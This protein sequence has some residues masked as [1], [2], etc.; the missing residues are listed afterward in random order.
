MAKSRGQRELQVGHARARANIALAKYWGK[1]DRRLNLPAVP[2]VSLTLDRLVTETQVT[3]DPAL[4]EDRIVLDGRRLNPG[5][6]KRMVE[7][8]RTIRKEAGITLRAEVRSENH[9][10]TAAGLASSASGFAAL[11]AATRQ[12]AGLPLDMNAMGRLARRSSASAARSLYGGFC[13]L[14]AGKTNDDR[15]CAKPLH[16]EHH[17]PELRL[18]V[19][20]TATGPKDVG[21]TDGMERSRKTS[22]LYDAWVAAAP[23]LT[24]KVKK[25]LREKNLELLGR[26]MEQSTMSFHSCAHS[27]DP[28]LVY[29]RPATLAAL[30]T[31][32]GLRKKGVSVYATMDAGPHVKSLCEKADLRRVT[33][34]LKR[35]EGVLDV[36]TCGP[37][38]GIEMW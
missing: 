15:L 9:F 11:V 31:I 34:A 10:P 25:G 23:G 17:W 21:S 6:T 37:G 4:K 5:K 18:V 12:A 2:S 35:T 32:R 8:L 36:W 3:F 29:W 28:P 22:P 33:H 27:S 16:D 19:A 20:L 24:R 38:A 13:E 1:L 30:E 26:A 14:P 7:V